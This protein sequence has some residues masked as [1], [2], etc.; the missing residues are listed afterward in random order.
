M[1]RTSSLITFSGTTFFFL[2]PLLLLL[3]AIFLFFS[4]PPLSPFWTVKL[5]QQT[6]KDIKYE[7][8]RKHRWK[9]KK[10]WYLAY[11]FL[12]II[13]PTFFF[14]Y[15]TSIHY[16]YQRLCSCCC[17]LFFFFA[18]RKLKTDF[19]FSIQPFLPIPHKKRIYQ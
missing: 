10:K 17:Y 6:T 4:P 1:K 18:I 14:A 12:R 9:V 11:I 16:F 7:N 5:Q 19:F 13:Y 3:F 8:N 2:F 15:Y